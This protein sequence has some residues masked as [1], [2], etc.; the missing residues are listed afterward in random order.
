MRDATRL[1]RSRLPAPADLLVGRD[2][3]LATLSRVL[4]SERARLVTLTGPP[5]VGKTRL[6][7]E[8]AAAY[9]DLTGR[10]A[11]FLDLAPLQDPG[12]VLTELA[13]AVGVEPRGGTDLIGQ[14]ATSWCKVLGSWRALQEP[15]RQLSR[16]E[17]LLDIAS[18]P[19]DGEFRQVPC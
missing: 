4:S 12:L 5:G 9:A 19:R 3:E 10:A 17:H 14:L 8:C 6:A 11:V 7:V 13:Q 2:R 15:F 16:D 18:W 1:P